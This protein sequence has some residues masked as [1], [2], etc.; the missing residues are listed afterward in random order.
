MKPWVWLVVIAISV[1]LWIAVIYA[2][3]AV[4]DLIFSVGTSG[5]GHAKF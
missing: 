3:Y 5:S 4:Y 2:A 1:V